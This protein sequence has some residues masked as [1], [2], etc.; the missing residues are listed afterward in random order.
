MRPDGTILA[1]LGYDSAT[2]LLLVD[3]LEMPPIP[4]CPT[5]ADARKALELIEGLLDEFVFADGTN[6]VSK[7]V[8]VSGIVTTVARAMFVV[9]PMHV[10][11]APVAGTGKSYYFDIIAV[12]V[13]GQ[14]MPVIPAGASEEELEKRLGAAMLASQQLITIDNVNG[15]LRGDALCQMIE[16]PRPQVR[17]LGRSELVEVEARGS[18]L[19]ANGNNIIV[20]GDLC[21]RVIRTRLN[22]K[23]ERPEQ[24]VF[25]GNPVQTVLRDRGA[26][27]AAALTIVRAYVAAGRPDKCKPLA[28][29]E[30][31]SDTVRSALVWLGMKDPVDSMES[32]WVDDPDTAALGALLAVWASMFG[33]G[34]ANRVALR[35]VIERA[36]AHSVD[37]DPTGARRPTYTHPELRAAVLA[38]VP[39]HHQLDAAH[40]GYWLRSRKDRIVKDMWFENEKSDWYVM[41]ADEQAQP[42]SSPVGANDES[43]M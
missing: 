14:R 37:V 20:A 25:T 36:N 34:Y 43:P 3:T 1:E 6:G 19:F 9:V 16:R 39:S 24:R 17:V 12:I 28:S 4:D 40:L 5:Q 41:R 2:R 32:V 18:T 31:W 7:A 22:A 21:R 8:A 29:F 27:I 13:T 23:M 15:T 30:E 38:A 33:T 10:A 11:D 26:Y 35:V 42:A